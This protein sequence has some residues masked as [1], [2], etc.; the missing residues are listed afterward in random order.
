MIED[1]S[2]LQFDIGYCVFVIRSTLNVFRLC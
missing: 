1:K 2:A